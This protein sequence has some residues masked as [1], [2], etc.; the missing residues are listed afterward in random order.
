MLKEK[1]E[2][3]YNTDTWLYNP[4]VVR[5]CVFCGV[6]RRWSVAFRLGKKTFGTQDAQT[7]SSN[8][9]DVFRF[10]TGVRPATRDFIFLIFTGMNQ[11]KMGFTGW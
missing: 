9:P 4:D 1:N 3:S 7:Y 6:R 8:F 5:V 2:S 10:V 11:N